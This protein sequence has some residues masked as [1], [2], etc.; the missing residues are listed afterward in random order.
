MF[1]LLLKKCLTSLVLAA[2]I[3]A[4]KAS[5]HVEQINTLKV[6]EQQIEALDPNALVVFDVD[7][8]ILI[9]K[10]AILN[11]VG[12]SLRS[13]IFNEKYQEAQ[14]LKEKEAVSA[15]LTVPLANAEKMLVEDLTPALI[16]KIQKKSIKTIALTNCPTGPCGVIEDCEKWR[17]DQL[18]KLGIN[19]NKSFPN[20]N[21][22]TF[23]GVEATCIK[24][25]VYN[26]GVIF[27]E[28][29]SKAEALNEFLKIVDFKPSQIIFVDNM[30]H[31][32]QQMETKCRSK[33]IPFKGYYYVRVEKSSAHEIN[34]KVARYQYNYLFE[35]G[36]WLSDQEA[37]D[38]L[39]SS[40][41]N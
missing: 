17:L 10:D 8:V 6:M 5:A 34:E 9:D 32:L 37:N 24:A 26:N 13:E 29:L 11:Q 2:V 31:H 35:H 12:D 41:S 1:S 28:G 39:N 14:T 21:R 7:D 33:K 38:H 20:L 16:D 22:V 23:K 27:A 30:Y 15:L 40:H 18:Q 3:F 4:A 36:V 25:P 19:F